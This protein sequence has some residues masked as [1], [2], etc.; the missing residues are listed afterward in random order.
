MTAAV[1][2]NPMLSD[3]AAAPNTKMVFDSSS[4]PGEIIDIMMVNTATLKENPHFG[5]AL[6]GA[7]YEMM[8]IMSSPGE[9]ALR[10]HRNW[11]KPP[12]LI[13]PCFDSQLNDADFLQ[14][15][16]AVAFTKDPK[17]ATPCSSVRSS[18]SITAFSDQGRRGRISSRGVL[19]GKIVGDKSKVTLRF[20]P[21]I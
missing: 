19:G 15:A 12:A 11:R 21:T 6:V 7:W 4:I 14:P 17:L 13:S 9:P 18:C 8:G 5:K 20:D 16:D 3:L 10:A 1:T 2:W